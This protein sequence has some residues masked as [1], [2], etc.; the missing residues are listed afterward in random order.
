MGHFIDLAV[1]RLGWGG[2]YPSWHCKSRFITGLKTAM[3]CSKIFLQSINDMITVQIVVSHFCQEF[4][5]GKKM[6]GFPVFGSSSSKRCIACYSFQH[7]PEAF[8]DDEGVTKFPFL[9]T[10]KLW[11]WLTWQTDFCYRRLIRGRRLSAMRE[12]QVRNY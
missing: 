5:Y 7:F 12:R 8:M 6:Q 11:T 2:T 1:W 10:G 3:H 4:M 9:C